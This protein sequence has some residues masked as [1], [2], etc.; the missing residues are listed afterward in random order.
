[1]KIELTT[2]HYEVSDRIRSHV[3]S[4]V[5]KLEKFHDRIVNCKVIL[6]K[7]KGGEKVEIKLHVSGK[8]MYT[9]DISDEM[10]KSVDVAVQRMG[11]QL[12]KFKGKRYAR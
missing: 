3:M 10:I 12:K 11:R 8:D 2:R 1:M 9:S 6:E 7:S 5:E 4:E